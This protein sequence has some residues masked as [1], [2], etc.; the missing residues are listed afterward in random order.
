[1]QNVKLKF[2]S[3]NPFFFFLKTTNKYHCLKITAI[4]NLANKD[5]DKAK[6]FLI[7]I[8]YCHA[9]FLWSLLGANRCHGLAPCIVLNAELRELV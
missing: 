4:V 7:Q 6:K 1:M 2:S 9:T 5:N 8:F 3:K